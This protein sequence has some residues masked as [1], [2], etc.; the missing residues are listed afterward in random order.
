MQTEPKE[1]GDVNTTQEESPC[2]VRKPPLNTVGNANLA[3]KHRSTTRLRLSLRFAM[4]GPR[5]RPRK[6]KK[7]KRGAGKA[8]A[9]TQQSRCTSDVA[10][11]PVSKPAAQDS[12]PA[13][14]DY[15]PRVDGRT[16]KGIK[17]YL[18]PTGNGPVLPGVWDFLGTSFADPPALSDVRYAPFARH[19][20][21][22][23]LRLY[24]P[25]ELAL[26]WIY[27]CNGTYNGIC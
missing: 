19:D 18:N 16:H 15:P 17:N 25:E 1:L 11:E 7:G 22:D 6:P 21:L 4:P 20:V 26:V 2:K 14:P 5:N 8:P 23:I 9:T 12:R 27:A 3:C 24:L 10:S 13:E